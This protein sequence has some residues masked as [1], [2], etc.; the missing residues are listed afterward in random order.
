[1]AIPPNNLNKICSTF[2]NE[3]LIQDQEKLIP[4]I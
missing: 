2:F 1:M 3:Y 4:K